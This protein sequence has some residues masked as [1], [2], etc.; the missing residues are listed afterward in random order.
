[1]F[2]SEE[3]HYSF[4]K[5]S[6]LLGLGRDNLVQVAT[7]EKGAMSVAALRSEIEKVVQEGGSPFFIG[8]TAGSTVRGA[9][10]SIA[11]ICKLGR[12]YDIWVHVD[13]AW[14]GSAIFSSRPDIQKL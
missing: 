5:C 3:A 6:G 8:C 11:E 14:G 1:M 2:V 4:L 13:G 7:D 10:D 9:F 12:E